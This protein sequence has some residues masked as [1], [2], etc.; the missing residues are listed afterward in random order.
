[1]INILHQLLIP[2]VLTLSILRLNKLLKNHFFDQKKMTNVDVI[3]DILDKF[4]FESD[5]VASLGKLLFSRVRV[6][7]SDRWKYSANR[8]RD[9]KTWQGN[10]KRC[11]I[12]NWG[13]S[14]K[15]LVDTPRKATFQTLLMSSQKN[16]GNCQKLIQKR[17]PILNSKSCDL[18][19]KCF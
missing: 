19:K 5:P 18:H 6:Q 17:L 7:Q 15:H 16:H 9:C 14:K 10:Q 3:C 11:Q 1:M 2:S 13:L 4:G 12:Q 8:G